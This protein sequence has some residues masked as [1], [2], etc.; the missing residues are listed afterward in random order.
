MLQSDKIWNFSFNFFL[1]ENY[2]YYD[3]LSLIVM[4]DMCEAPPEELV[5]TWRSGLG[6]H[7][8]ARPAGQICGN[9]TSDSVL[10]NFV[11][12]TI[13]SPREQSIFAMLNF[14]L[15]FLQ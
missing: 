11:G 8:R 4:Y 1:G 12:R 13:A 7:A 3:S 15:D 10:Q 9:T 6:G 2:D 5:Q 14:T